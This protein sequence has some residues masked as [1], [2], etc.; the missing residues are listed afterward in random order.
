LD[1][2]TTS[3]WEFSKEELN[4]GDN[5]LLELLIIDSEAILVNYLA[6]SENLVDFCLNLTF[7]NLRVNIRHG[8][9]IML[10]QMWGC[11]LVSWNIV[12]TIF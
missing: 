1:E 8:E 9:M 10:F 3:G 7:I 5:L 12:A 6:S 4:C 2:L 11:V